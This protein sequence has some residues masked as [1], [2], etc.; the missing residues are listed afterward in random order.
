MHGRR[1]SNGITLAIRDDFGEIYLWNTVVGNTTA[2]FT[3]PDGTGPSAVA[4]EPDGTTLIIGNADGSVYRW[5][6]PR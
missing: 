1:R 3:S 4:F 6:I 5:A 2:T